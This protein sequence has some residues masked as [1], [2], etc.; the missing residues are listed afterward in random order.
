MRSTFQ[1]TIH[2]EIIDHGTVFIGTLWEL[3]TVLSVEF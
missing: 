1:I 2:N 3:H